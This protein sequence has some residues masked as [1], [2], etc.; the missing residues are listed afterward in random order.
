LFGGTALA[1]AYTSDINSLQ[2]NDLTVISVNQASP[3]F[4]Q[5]GY[6]IPAGLPPCPP[7]GCICSWNWIHQS[8]HGEGYGAEIY[9][10]LYRCTVTGNTD[11]SKTVQKGVV[12]RDCTGKPGSCVKGPKTPMYLYQASG[13]NLP[14]LAVPPNYND[15]WGFANGAQNDIFTAATNAN[16]NAPTPTATSLPSGWTAMGCYKDQDPRSLP[17]FLSS[18]SNNTI[19]SCVAGCAA[20]GNQFA[21]VEGNECWCAKSNPTL[22]SAPDSDCTSTCGGDM[23]ST[24]GGNWRLNVYKGPAAVTAAP[25]PLASAAIPSGWAAVGCA[26]DSGTS[27]TLDR[28]STYSALMTVQKCLDIAQSKGLPYAGV[29][30]GNECWVG[31]AA[32]QSNIQTG[33][34]C[35]APCGGDQGT[36]CG[37]AY[38]LNVYVNNALLGAKPAASSSSSSP[39][40]T[41]SSKAAASTPTTT[42]STTTSSAAAATSSSA[43]P[44]G[45]KD[46]GCLKDSSQRLLNGASLSWTGSMTPKKCI[47]FCTSKGFKYAGTENGGECY[48]GNTVSTAASVS[49]TEC[50]SKCPGGAGFCGGSWKLSLYQNTAASKRDLGRRR[51]RWENRHGDPMALH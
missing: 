26:T 19:E 38:R 46:L 39:T 11:S 48:C 42:S 33:T 6:D 7:G 4:R 13:N 1:I 44:A 12:P 31:T 23:W 34:G 28:G 25:T 37:G 20:G 9:N 35:T 41:T 5:T 14:S 40:S 8:A 17:I 22:V 49:A 2:P 43:L 30:N 50:N 15:N 32:S 27:R 47:D 29:E 24:C 36:T 10:L 3:W 21:G 45:W 51:L 16:G 18:S